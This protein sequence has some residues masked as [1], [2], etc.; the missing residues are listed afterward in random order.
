MYNY[1]TKGGKELSMNDAARE[2]LQKLVLQA[3]DLFAESVK[4]YTDGNIDK[5]AALTASIYARM[6]FLYCV[7]DEE[8]KAFLK[9][10]DELLYI[11]ML[12]GNPELEKVT[13]HIESMN[14]KK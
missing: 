9:A 4:A 13:K 10:G 1:K 7:L 11:L 2:G 5:L 8:D 6:D 14:T 3:S 12:V